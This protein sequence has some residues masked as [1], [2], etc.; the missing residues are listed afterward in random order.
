[1]K[2]F[3]INLLGGYTK[4]EFEDKQLNLALIEKRIGAYNTLLNLRHFAEQM[5]GISA[6][7]W[8]KRMYDHICGSI[9]R[10]EAEIR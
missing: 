5:N 6:D 10:L 1:M 3:I 7:E 2:K 8:S 4:D 9:K